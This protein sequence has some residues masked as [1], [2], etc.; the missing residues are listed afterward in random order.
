MQHLIVPLAS[1][2]IRDWNGE[3][4][5]GLSVKDILNMPPEIVATTFWDGDAH[6]EYSWFWKIE[7][8]LNE[9][10]LASHPWFAKL[11]P[12]LAAWMRIPQ[13]SAVVDRLERIA[14]IR[15]QPLKIPPPR[16]SDDL[17]FVIE[18]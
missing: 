14:R 10:N 16:V 17:Q 8:H 1:V 12:E 7:P 13:R 9:N 6:F 2:E 4:A 3:V 11:T 18:L 5:K 15:E